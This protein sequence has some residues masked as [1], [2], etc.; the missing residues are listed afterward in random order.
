[1]PGISPGTATSILKRIIALEKRLDETLQPANLFSVD[2]VTQLISVVVKGGLQLIETTSNSI[3]PG[4]AISWLSSQAD[5]NITFVEAFWNGIAHELIASVQP[6]GT[7]LGSPQASITMSAQEAGAAG[8]S[9]LQVT[10]ADATNG[11]LVTPPQLTTRTI[12]DSNGNSDYMFTKQAAMLFNPQTA[13][14]LGAQAV[15]F[16]V[17]GFDPLNAFSGGIWVAPATGFYI[18]TV[19]INFSAAQAYTGQWS[20]NGVLSGAATLSQPQEQISAVKMFSLAKGVPISFTITA[21]AAVG[22]ILASSYLGMAR[23]G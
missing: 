9:S 20:N 8:T 23:I 18:G 19:F 4:Q 22:N 3:V 1:M 6:G 11:F 7:F 21:P 14:V 12:L 15:A 16:T 5:A 13:V 2:P 17:P 10:A